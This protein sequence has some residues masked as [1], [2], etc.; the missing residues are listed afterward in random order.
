MFTCDTGIRHVHWTIGRLDIQMSSGHLDISVRPLHEWT[1]LNL[2]DGQLDMSICPL[3]KWTFKFPLD[4]SVCVK[5]GLHHVLDISVLFR[6]KWQYNY[7]NAPCFGKHREHML[8][9]F[10]V[11]ILD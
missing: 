7:T 2:R 4:I 5:D 8:L 11:N 10:K 1:Y 9:C 6:R 3:N